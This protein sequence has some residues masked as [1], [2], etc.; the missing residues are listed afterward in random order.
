MLIFTRP[1]G[2]VA[3]SLQAFVDDRKFARID[4]HLI[5]ESKAFRCG[6]HSYAEDSPLKKIRHSS[7][8]RG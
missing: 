1:R 5:E 8:D 2:I 7:L 3:Q 4:P 6:F